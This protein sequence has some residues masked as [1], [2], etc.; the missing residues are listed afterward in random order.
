MYVRAAPCWTKEIKATHFST[1][2]WKVP[3]FS[4]L[5]NMNY[6]QKRLLALFFLL[7]Q[8]FK[9]NKYN[10][11]Y[12][13]ICFR[14]TQDGEGSKTFVQSQQNNNIFVTDI[15]FWFGFVFLLWSQKVTAQTTNDSHNYNIEKN[16]ESRHQRRPLKDRHAD[17]V[18]SFEAE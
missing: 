11:K 8:H 12:V 4:L 14:R 13:Y 3:Y 9:C 16:K 5:N 2:M 10:Q 1:W 7:Q 6:P 18:V 15:Q 17:C